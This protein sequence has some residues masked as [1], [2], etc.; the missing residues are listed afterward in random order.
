MTVLSDRWESIPSWPGYQASTA[1]QIRSHRTGKVLA[2]NTKKGKHPYQRVHLSQDGKAR[3]VLVHRL[4]LDT[5]MGPCPEGQQALHLDDNPRNNS[6]GN[7][8]WGTPKENHSTINRH[9][10]ANGRSKLTEDDVRAIRASTEPHVVLARSLSVSDT[11]IQNIRN[12][13]L[14]PHV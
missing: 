13:R 5:F 7:L 9:G 2:Q 1:G 11:T 3:Y 4:I 10:R 8:R 14:W 12:H 6:L